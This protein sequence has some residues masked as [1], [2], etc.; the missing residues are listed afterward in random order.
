MNEGT[1]SNGLISF[2]SDMQIVDYFSGGERQMRKPFSFMCFG[3]DKQ[4]HGE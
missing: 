4:R 1:I 3:S 2:L